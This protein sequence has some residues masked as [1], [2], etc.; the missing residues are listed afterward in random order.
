MYDY[1]YAQLVGSLMYLAICTRPDISFAVGKLGQF[2]SNPGIAY[3]KAAQHLLHYL[4]GTKSYKLTYAPDPSQT[5]LFTSY[6]NA[7]FAGDRSTRRST[8]GMV[9]KVGTGAVKYVAAVTAGQEVIWLRYLLTELGYK[10]TGPSTLFL[11]N[12]SAVQV[13]KNPEHYSRIK[14]LDLRLYWLRDQVNLGAIRILYLKTDNMPA[15]LMTKALERMKVKGFTK[16]IGVGD[17]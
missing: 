2:S 17:C 15:D 7:D 10:F 3:W 16:M 4:Q 5:E 14:H 13:A 8:S 11:D 12:N 1:P 6:T 9:I